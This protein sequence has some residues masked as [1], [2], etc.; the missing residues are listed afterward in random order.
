MDEDM[1][2]IELDDVNSL[3]EFV[4]D[5]LL[6]QIEIMSELTEKLEAL[7]GVV[8]RLERRVKALEKQTPE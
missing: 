3:K 2:G 6:K 8:L 4:I 7:Y 5:R 1:H